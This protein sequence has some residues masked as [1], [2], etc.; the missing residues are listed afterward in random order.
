MI[1]KILKIMGLLLI[2]VALCLTIYIKVQSDNAEKSSGYILGKLT[3]EMEKFE[4]PENFDAE[5][6]ET[7]EIDNKKYMGIIEIPDIDVKLPIIKDWNYDN[8]KHSPCRYSGSIKK[9]NIIICAHNYV[10]QFGR[11][12]KLSNGDSIYITK[13]GGN[14]IEYKVKEI[15]KINQKD[16]E[17]MKNGGSW[18]LTL[19]TCNI[20]GQARITVRCEKVK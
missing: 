18:D 9:N 12:S 16:I 20:T 6:D 10:S 4:I 19:F 17:Q 13:I 11:L 2:I 14:K 5:V 8:L 3:E 7:I 1:S 15:G